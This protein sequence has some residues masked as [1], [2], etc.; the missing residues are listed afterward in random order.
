MKVLGLHNCSVIGPNQATDKGKGFLVNKQLV[1]IDEI[2]S[3]DDWG[4]RNTLLNDLKPMMTED[5]HEVRPLW[6]DYR[7]VRTCTNYF[8]FIEGFGDAYSEYLADVW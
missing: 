6:K 5:L 4:E 3:K 7:T 2:K 8:L 1:L